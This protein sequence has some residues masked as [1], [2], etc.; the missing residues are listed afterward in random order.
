[1]PSSQATASKIQNLLSNWD[2]SSPAQRNDILTK[3]IL[4]SKG[5]TATELDQEFGLAASLFLSRISAWLRLTYLIGTHVG[6]QINAIYVFV[7]ST[8]GHEFM[9]EFIEVG[10]ILTLLEIISLKQSKE[11]DKS[12]A[13]KL[14]NVIANAGRHHKE[15]ICE[16]YGIRAIAECLAKARS[17]E[18]QDNARIMLQDLAQG[19][20]KYEVQV[21]KGLI[22][23]LPT[24]SPKAQQMALQSLRM[25]QPIVKN[26]NPS[27][28]EPVLNLLSSVHLEVQYEAV[29]FIREL[30]R[31]D[32]R[33][34]ILEGLVRSLKP[35]REDLLARNKTFETALSLA[36]EFKAALP[37]FVKQAAAAKTI[38][39]LCRDSSAY[40]EFFL[41]LRVVNRILIAMGNTDYAD[42]QRQ[43]SLTL[44]YLI[45][46]FPSVNESVKNAMGEEL[47]ELFMADPENLYLKLN[48]IQT[49][50]L[51]SNKVNL[52]AGH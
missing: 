8:G 19:N 6:S 5:K 35:S 44:E 3:F 11:E 41:G 7:A 16:S 15:L 34:H 26:V 27:L 13:L 2:S 43:A 38:G 18:T 12:D 30:M 47:Y 25:A 48:P 42:S 49:D 51:V 29:E 46:I 14:L 45:R 24:T 36:P 20:P 23:L 39:I 21:Y 52:A 10:G 32:I 1:M 50:V 40:A 4:N 33:D 17:E 37:A 28:V 31:Y 9:E 22:A